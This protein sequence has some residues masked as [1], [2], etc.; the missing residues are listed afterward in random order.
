MLTPAEKLFL[1][2]RN[3][4]CK[5][6]CRCADGKPPGRCFRQP[7]DGLETCDE[8][9]KCVDNYCGGCWAEFF[10]RTGMQVCKSPAFVDQA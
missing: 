5:G 7:C 4:C 3:V 8:A 9:A 1:D 6:K 10:T 2:T